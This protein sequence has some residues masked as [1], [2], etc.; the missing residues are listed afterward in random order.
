MIE[1]IGN[2]GNCYGGFHV[3][4]KDG[5]Y[6]WAIENYDGTYWEEIPKELYDMLIK[7][8]SLPDS[9]NNHSYGD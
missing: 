8:R 4:I 5:L 3:K 2:I 7:H 6:F 1:R 9:I